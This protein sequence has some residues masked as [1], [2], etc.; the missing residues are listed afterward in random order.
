MKYFVLSFLL[1]LSL[2]SNGQDTLKIK[3][4]YKGLLIGISVSPDYCNRILSSP[5]DGTF[6][7]SF[8]NLRD[9]MEKYKIG[10]TGGININY[11]VSKNLGFEI[12]VQ[13]SN[14]GYSTKAIE[15]TYG[16]AIDPRFGFT[17]DSLQPNTITNSSPVKNIKFVDNLIYLDIPARAILNFGKNKIRFITSFGITTNILLEAT[18]TTVSEYENGETKSTTQDQPYEYKTLGI[19]P[20]FS[21]GAA[22]KISNK[23]KLTAEPTVRYG[24][25]NINDAPITVNLW[26]IGFNVG[27]Y[28]VLKKQP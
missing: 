14:K 17:Y 19:S 11:D 7:S 6:Y 13:Y 26:S 25:L 16:D 2:V 28:Y 15:L 10:F 20:T 12:G 8:I 24:L 22:Y 23:F 5:Y 27:F 4:D 1:I 18:T 3:K 9:D 21:I